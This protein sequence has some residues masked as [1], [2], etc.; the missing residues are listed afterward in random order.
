MDT[1]LAKLH[2]SMEKLPDLNT[3]IDQP[4]ALDLAELEPELVKSRRVGVLCKLYQKRG[5]DAKLLDVW[6][7]LVDGE[8]RDPE[9][10]DPLTR[11]FDLLTEKKDKGLIQRWTPWLVKKDSDRALK[12][13]LSRSLLRAHLT[14]AVVACYFDNAYETENGRRSTASTSDTGI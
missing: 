11:I 5:E 10:Q 3:L 6:S 14:C 2:V 13:G 8:F 9:V 4:N 1:A 7:K 12:V